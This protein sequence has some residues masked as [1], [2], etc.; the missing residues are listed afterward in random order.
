RGPDQMLDSSGHASEADLMAASG[1]FEQIAL[2]DGINVDR[3]RI[4][5]AVDEAAE[6]Y[7][8][9]H[10]GGWWRWSIETGHSLSRNCRVIDGELG[11]LAQLALDGVT[12]IVRS[13]DGQNWHML[14]KGQGRTIVFGTPC[15]NVP[16]RHTNRRKVAKL[17]KLEGFT[18]VLR[19]VVVEP[20][21]SSDHLPAT[22]ASEQ[23]PLNRLIALLQPEAG[24]VWV[25]LVFALVSGLLGMTTPL[26]VEALVNTVA[27]GRFLQPVVVLSLMLLAFLVFQAA[28]K[29]LQTF[30]VEIIQR[31]LFAR[32]AADLSFRL[33]KARLEAMDKYYPPELVNRFFDVMTVQK[34]TAQL[35]LDGVSIVLSALVGMAVLAFYHPYLLAF[36]VALILLLLFTFLVLGRGAISTSIK[37]SKT[38][39]AMAA[40]LEDLA[41]CPTAFRY[42][43]A[44]E[45]ALE[46]SD[47]LIFDYLAARKKHFRVFIRQILFLLLTQALA[48]TALLA[49][50]GLLVIS[51]QLSL[52]QLVAAELI[53]AVVVGSFAKLGKHIESFYDLM[54]S[55]DKLGSLFD[56]PIERTDGLLVA[57]SSSGVRVENVSY[58][59]SDGSEV[60]NNVSLEISPGD[61]LALCG[62]SGTGKSLLLDM[63]FGM[64]E[65]SSG[66]VTVS[67]VDP[68]DLR[69]DVLR[70]RVAMARDVEIF[71]G[72]LGTNIHLERP[73]ISISDVRETLEVVGLSYGIQS[74]SEGLDTHIT[75]RG[76]PL[77]SGQL[78]RIMIA[79]ALVG[80]PEVLLI[81]ELLDTFADH[82]SLEILQRMQSVFPQMAILIVTNREHLKS[83]ASRVIQLE[84]NN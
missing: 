72:T 32:I 81:D 73:D 46:R 38:K 79:R 19:A 69:P 14:A 51:G 12:V 68:R 22:M 75:P 42:D 45:F 25:V 61:Q 13:G 57:P 34:V 78:K 20:S 40:W 17:L 47:Q 26:A 62:E 9:K 65:P 55:V 44:S 28:M 2:R 5:R 76:A 58:K 53:V 16:I 27:F 56:L 66:L 35:L 82:E 77:T 1:I 43:G 10:D 33:P 59:R 74:L 41:R 52:G 18:G 83:F 15:G 49:I 48:S 70:R 21:L 39:Y 31:R 8:G 3:S 60:L 84:R 6:T 64:R 24:D 23:R 30:V 67:G 54:A 71:D 7:F 36:D 4:R 11:E 50:G 37:E 80:R 63:L 29:A